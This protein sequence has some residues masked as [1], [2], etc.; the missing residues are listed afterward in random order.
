MRVRGGSGQVL[1]PCA[2]FLAAMRY[3]FLTPEFRV[4]GLDVLDMTE[5]FKV[6]GLLFVAKEL[7]CLK[8]GSVGLGRQ[9]RRAVQLKSP[10][11]VLRREYCLSGIP[12]R[13][14]RSNSWVLTRS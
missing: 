1:L 3:S 5:V 14:M 13:L 4:L 11:R 9:W 7:C 2:A 12:L 10:Y 8:L 6:P